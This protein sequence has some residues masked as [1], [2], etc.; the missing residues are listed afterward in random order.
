MP[1]KKRPKSAP[2]GGLG[3]SDN[4][5][6]VSQRR[7]SEAWKDTDYV[8]KVQRTSL[9]EESDSAKTRWGPGSVHSADDPVTSTSATPRKPLVRAKSAPLSIRRRRSALQQRQLSLTS[10]QRNNPGIDVDLHA[11]DSI[12]R[13]NTGKSGFV[14]PCRDGSQEPGIPNKQNQL[15]K[16]LLLQTPARGF[17]EKR[18]E[19]KCEDDVVYKVTNT[20]K[21][22]FNI[23]AIF[24]LKS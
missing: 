24:Y 8:G 22:A 5:V 10:P 11:L 4:V 6:E 3:K 21:Y 12:G 7:I 18:K 16:T 13:A 1:L 19:Q 20:G 17:K 2:F 14:R 15:F 9:P 23:T